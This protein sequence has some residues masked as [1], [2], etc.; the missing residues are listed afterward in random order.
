M[1]FSKIPTISVSNEAANKILRMVDLNLTTLKKKIEKTYKPAS[2]ELKGVSFTLKNRTETKLIKSPNVLGYIEGSDPKLKNEVIVIGAHLDHL[3]KRGDYIFNGADDNGS[4]SAGVLELA[5]AFALN[6]KKPK[7][8]ILFALWT[9]EE[10][11]LLGSRYYVEHPAFPIT[12]TAANINLDM[13]S[14]EWDRKRLKIMSR[15]F[16]IQMSAE[17][18]KKLDLS[19]FISLS[20]D[21]NAPYYRDIVEKSNKYVGLTISFK[22]TKNIFSGGGGSDHMPFAFLKIPWGF[23]SAGFTKDYHQPSDS[24]KYVSEKMMKLTTRLTYLTA[25]SLADR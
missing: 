8:T 19:K 22:G 10:K 16:G 7:R 20:F 13:I 18:I 4:G 5:Q 14:R 11:G 25:F 1:P 21:A 12:K 3:G 9:G 23:F 6:P 24:L 15:F 17:Q 2:R